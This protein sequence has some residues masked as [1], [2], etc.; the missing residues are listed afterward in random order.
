MHAGQTHDKGRVKLSSSASS[1]ALGLRRQTSGRIRRPGVQRMFSMVAWVQARIEL[2]AW[3]QN[4]SAYQC[5]MGG[6]AF[7][8]RYRRQASSWQ[9]HRH[10]RRAKTTTQASDVFNYQRGRFA[11]PRNALREGYQN[12]STK[13]EIRTA[14]FSWVLGRTTN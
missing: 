3:Y 8:G 14:K 11:L 9:L 2:R 4:T 5:R 6:A 7:P 1:K 12:Y 10:Y 13:V